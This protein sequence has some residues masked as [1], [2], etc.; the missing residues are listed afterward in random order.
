MASGLL[1]LQQQSCYSNYFLYPFKKNKAAAIPPIIIITKI[2][3]DS[4]RVVSDG[5]G[6]S[7]SNEKIKSFSKIDV[8]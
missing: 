7:P 5:V 2:T 6:S 4:S 8:S 3:M 1:S